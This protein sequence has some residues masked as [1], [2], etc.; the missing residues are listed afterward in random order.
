[1][2]TVSVKQLMAAIEEA[3][4]FALPDMTDGAQ[5]LYDNLYARLSRNMEV[6]LSDIDFSGFELD[7][8]D[9]MRELTSDLDSREYKT[10][11]ITHSLRKLSPVASAAA[12]V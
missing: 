2:I 11:A 4:S 3:E 10:K 5:Y 7:D 9:F 1:M 6:R 8:I 12:F